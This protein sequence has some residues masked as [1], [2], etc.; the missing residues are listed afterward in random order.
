MTSNVLAGILSSLD[1]VVFERVA[2]GIFLRIEPAQPPSWFDGVWP[3]ASRNEP[4][5]LAQAFPFLESFLDEAEDVW[6]AAG[7]RRL[8]SDPFLVKDRAGG[9][10]TLVASAVSVGRRSFV[11]L[12]SPG[13]SEE[14]RRTLQ[15]ARD[16]ALAYEE[17][18]RRTGE[19]LVPVRAAQ[20]LVQQLATAGLPTEQQNQVNA[21]HD[22]L[23]AIAESIEKLAPLPR[24][25]SRG[26]R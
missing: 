26:R 22:R 24:G 16:R 21:V 20:Q 6:S 17:H 11:V 15:G 2:E 19:L 7:D 23:A 8:R 14:R 18:V 10:S 13:D 4:V 9:D 3:D 5:A 25:V 1:L 12:E